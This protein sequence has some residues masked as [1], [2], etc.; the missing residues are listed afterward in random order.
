[1]KT[2]GQFAPL[3]TLALFTGT[4]WAGGNEPGG[5]TSPVSPVLAQATA[6]TVPTDLANQHHFTATAVNSQNAARL[7]Q[8]W[9]IQTEHEV[10]HV[11]LVDGGHVYF[12]DWGGNAYAADAAS[13]RILWKKNLEK[14]V[15]QWPWHG[16]A[17]SGALGEGMLFEASAEGYVFA[18]DQNT[19][20]VRWKTDFVPESQ[21]GGNLTRIVYYDGLLYVGG[22]SVE[23][24][25]D[26]MMKQMGK[27][28]T[29]S[30][31]GKVTA[32]NAKTGK[33]VWEQ[34]LVQAPQNGV[35]V[36][37]G[38][39]VDPE[40]NALFTTT[41][42]NYTGEATANSDAVMALDLKT[43]AIKWST[44][45]TPND[46]WTKGRPIGPDFDFGAA[47]QLFEANV[48]G[49]MRQLVGAGQKSGYFHAL[50][51][52]TGERVWSNFVGYG[53]AGGGIHADAAIANSTVY[54]WSNNNYTYAAPPEK[55]PI[56]VMALDAATGQPRWRVE[57]DKSQ[58]ANV[59]AS[60]VLANDAY[61]VGSLDGRFRAYRAS[62]GKK[63]W[64]SPQHGEIGTAPV[65]VGNSM[66]FGVG[67]PKMFGNL[68][69][70]GVYAYRLGQ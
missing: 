68:K 47:P 27:P 23:E 51:R 53:A 41:G 63:V 16:F 65:F 18:L 37:S 64:T 10:T 62:D 49:Q 35:P 22:S 28:F 15:M 43:G 40:M 57:G 3:L 50:D 21:Y 46:V 61:F 45:L 7:Q 9:H 55:H 69:G 60:G 6:G 24:P 17:G 25:I 56:T 12:A 52:Q 48:N 19:G 1:M 34:K 2:A 54:A 66:Y 70:N 11:P 26:G 8:A 42:N 31:Q 59:P 44:Q 20:E 14:P 58:P 39:A 30:F 33:V 5:Q 29:P 4:A 67:V 38:F 36:W 13:G 32:I